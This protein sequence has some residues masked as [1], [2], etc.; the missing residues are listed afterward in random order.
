MCR[1][2]T[3]LAVVVLAWPGQAQETKSFAE[4]QI[5]QV[6]GKLKILPKVKVVQYDKVIYEGPI[7]LNPTL[8]RIRAG[9]KLEHRNDGAIFGN[10]EGLLP[11]QRDRQYYR[12]FVVRMKGMPFP[13]PQRLVLGKQGEAYYTADHYSSFQRVR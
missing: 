4:P 5:S 9:K 11:K 10:R 3:F 2:L 7:D 1:V 13:G 8:T 12:E 6:E